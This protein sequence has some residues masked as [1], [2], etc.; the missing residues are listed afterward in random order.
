MPF[1]VLKLVK[2]KVNTKKKTSERLMYVQFTSC[3]QGGECK[4]FEIGNVLREI[5]QITIT[6]T[7]LRFCPY[8]GKY[9]SE[10]TRILTYFT[11][12]VFFY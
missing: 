3:V 7:S 12:W 5:C 11:Q 6:D 2:Q 9:G 1:N 8:T 10:K 4:L